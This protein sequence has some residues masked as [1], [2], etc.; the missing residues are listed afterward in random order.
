M[1]PNELQALGTS[2]NDTFK[3]NYNGQGTFR[4]VG[5]LVNDSTLKV[6][7]MVVVNLLNRSVMREESEKAYSE[8]AQAC[9]TYLKG[10]KK[11]FKDL[12][13]RALKTKELSVDDSI[14]LMTMSVYS[15]VG[16][17]LVR[18]VYT[19]EVS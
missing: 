18:C 9:N 7:C 13:G 3:N 14:E 19:F 4:I 11:E 15:P 2:V 1:E 5:K 16:T 12:T 17:A 10:V 6:T 8:L